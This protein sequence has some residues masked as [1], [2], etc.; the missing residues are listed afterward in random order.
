[1][2]AAGALD[3]IGVDG[4]A[5]DRGDRVLQLGRLVQPVGVERDRHV[6]RVGEAQDVVDQLGVGA[7]VLVDLEAARRRRRAARR[8][9]PSSSA[10]APAW[11]PML[12]GQPSNAASV[13]SIAHG[14]S[15][16]PAVMS[17][18]TPPDRAA[19]MSSGR[20]RVDVAVDRA[21]RRD[22]PVGH[23]RLGVR[24]DGRS[25]PSLMAG[26]PARPMPDDPAVLDADVRLDDADDG[27]ED[28][29]RRR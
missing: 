1:M 29:R 27:I 20:D 3:V 16:K 21:R 9:A 11:S 7:V 19:G 22:Q 14:G 8:G 18:V 25:M 26:L 6:V 17:V 10:R 28:E 15:S 13:R 12:S 2:P 24:P 5:G 23:D 4:P